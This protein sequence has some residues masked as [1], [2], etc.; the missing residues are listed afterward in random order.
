MGAGL[1]PV[2]MARQRSVQA[3]KR[4]HE[5]KRY[6]QKLL[7]LLYSKYTNVTDRVES[8][9]SIMAADGTVGFYLPMIDQFRHSTPHSQPVG[10]IF[11]DGSFLTVKEVFRYDYPNAD[12]TEAEII[13]FEFSYHYQ[14][15]HRDFFFRYDYHP[16]AG[17]A[18]THP[19]YHLH[20]GCWHEGDDK[21]PSLPRFRVPPVTLEEVLDL[22]GRDLLNPR[23]PART[24][25]V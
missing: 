14:I 6:Q 18:A 3:T 20:V 7:S 11:R 23:E 9:T 2:G 17:D 16:G 15:P 22:I 8:Q 10:I 19:P 4:K 25:N 1:Y 5:A 24:S 13:K 21:L 12:A